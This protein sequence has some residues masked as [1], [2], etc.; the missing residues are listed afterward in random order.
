MIQDSTYDIV[1]IGA[2][3]CGLA[4][5]YRLR[6]SDRK[7]L[8]LESRSRLGGR[9]ETHTSSKGTSIELGATWLGDKHHALVALLKELEIEV[10]PQYMGSHA[11]YEPISTSPHMIVQLPPN[12]PSYRIEGGSSRL[13]NVLAEHV[14]CDIAT[15]T[16]VSRLDFNGDHAIINTDQGA[17]RAHCVVS[18]LPPNLLQSNIEV[19]PTLPTS[20][21]SVMAQTHTWM[22][23]SIKVGL[24]Y[25]HPFWLED[26][27][28]GTIVSNVG[29]IPEM[30]DHSAH[31]HHALKGFLNGNYAALPQEER[32]SSRIHR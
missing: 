25:N 19:G 2:G 13:I 23:E 9:I 5:A 24:T 15:S 21:L 14:T 31:G 16:A 32:K 17:V 29:P 10:V 26:G 8:L 20:V 6:D 7:I 11:I 22:S 4:L 1:I 28:S 18:T 12:D 27:T 3:L 30:Y